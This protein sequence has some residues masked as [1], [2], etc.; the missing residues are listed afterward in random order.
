MRD[1]LRIQRDEVVKEGERGRVKRC[2]LGS[3][4]VLK[5]SKLHGPLTKFDGIRSI[6]LILVSDFTDLLGRETINYYV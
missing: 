1:E 4:R 5:L 6:R 2:P 3:H